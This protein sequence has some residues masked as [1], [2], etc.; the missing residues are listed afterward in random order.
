MCLAREN[1]A[2]PW[3]GLL[4]RENTA[5]PAPGIAEGMAVP[6]RDEAVTP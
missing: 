2:H 6:R 1:H 4:A 5:K 3:H